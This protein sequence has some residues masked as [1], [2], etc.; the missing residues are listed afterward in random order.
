MNRRTPASPAASASS[1]EAPRSTVSLRA[2]LLPGPAPA[3]NTTASVSA[4]T[5]ATS[6]AD[7]A[8]RSSTTGTAPVCSTS[9]A[10]AGLRISPTAWS[11]RSVSIRSSSSA[12]FPCPPAI[13]TRMR[14][15]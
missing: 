4:S 2:A 9:S 11:P 5:P 12:I 6:A 10:W 15:A 1:T 14:P 8:S 7:T 3:A 13:T